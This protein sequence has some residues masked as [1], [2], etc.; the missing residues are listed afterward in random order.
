MKTLL[1]HFSGLRYFTVVIY[2]L[3]VAFEAIPRLYSVPLLRIVGE[4]N[5]YTDGTRYIISGQCNTVKGNCRGKYEYDGASV[6]GSSI[7]GMNSVKSEIIRSTCIDVIFY[8]EHI[9]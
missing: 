1:H 9:R 4:W 2:S 6:S 7:S 8:F 3:C 5:L